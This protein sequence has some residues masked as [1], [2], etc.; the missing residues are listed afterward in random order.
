M[1]TR[2]KFLLNCSVAAAGASLAP[3]GALAG[4][5]RR[6]ELPV[7]QLGFARFAGQVDT[8]FTV[9][10]GSGAVRLRLTEA[11]PLPD[12]DA[13]ADDAGNEK[14]SLIFRGSANRE[15]EQDTYQFEHPAAGRFAMFVVPIGCLDT[16]HCYYEAVFNRPVDELH[17]AAQVLQAP[18][19]TLKR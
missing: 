14:F 13:N 8:V 11:N 4:N 1:Q 2:R 15:L 12:V 16:R 3:A 19:R 17:F 5:A 18:G 9:R 7:E 10:T 6:R